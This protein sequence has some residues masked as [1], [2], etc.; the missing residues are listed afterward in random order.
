MTKIKKSCN[1]PKIQNIQ[2]RPENAG[3]PE[4]APENL[5][6]L[7]SLFDSLNS[8]NDTVSKLDHEIDKYFMEHDIYLKNQGN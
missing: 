4:Q 5:R 8:L 6:L 3:V 1:K 7:V 2:A